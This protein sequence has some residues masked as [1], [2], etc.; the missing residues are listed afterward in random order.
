MD[1]RHRIYAPTLGRF[2]QV[3]PIGFD[4]GDMNLFRY[5]GDDPVDRTDPLGLESLFYNNLESAIQ[6]AE[7]RTV[8]AQFSP[9]AKPIFVNIRGDTSTA[10]GRTISIMPSKMTPVLKSGNRYEVLDTMNGKPQYTGTNA[11]GKPQ[12]FELKGTGLSKNQKARTKAMIHIHHDIKENGG[13]AESKNSIYD[14]NLY[15]SGVIMER[16]NA[17]DKGRWWHRRQPANNRYGYKDS[18]HRH[19]TP[20]NGGGSSGS[21]DSSS[22][23][24]TAADVDRRH[25]AT[26]VPSLAAE[27]VNFAPGKP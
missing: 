13:V 1:F 15:K 18:K 7:A 20:H 2:L 6:A 5:C 8:A 14:D 24:P 19:G 23:G 27:A 4:A 9:S 11:A 12:F 26:G 16:M 21:S 17:S 3:D 25:Q 22:S 10:T